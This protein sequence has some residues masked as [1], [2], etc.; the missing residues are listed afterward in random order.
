M[1]KLKRII[2]KIIKSFPCGIQGFISNIRTRLVVFFSRPIKTD[3]IPLPRPW[4]K[5][6]VVC[7]VYKSTG[8]INFVWNSFKKYTAS[9]D[10]LFV[11]N[12]ATQKV[13]DYLKN[14]NLPHLIFENKD[15]NEHYLKRV[16]RAYNYG[17]INALGDI[18]VFVNSDMAFSPDW[19]PNLLK[20]LDKNRIVCS[21]LVESGKLLSGH[22]ALVKNFGKTYQNFND[23]AFQ[24]YAAKIKRP[25]LHRGGHFMPCAIY[26]DVFIKSGGYPIGNRKESDGSETPGDVIFFRE[27]LEPMGVYKYTSFDSIVYHIQEGELDE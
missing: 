14:K 6:T 21:R 23:A 7:S 3:K 5:V 12:D 10:F 4:P 27:K 20:N 9:T 17:G 18:I 22:L 16:Y 24:K 8:Y 1:T 15:K 11:A 2:K 25:K 26:K 13:K 19:L